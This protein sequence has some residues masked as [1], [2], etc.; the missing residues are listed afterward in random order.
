M[1][2]FLFGE[3]FRQQDEI[4]L[5]SFCRHFVLGGFYLDSAGKQK[6]RFPWTTNYDSRLKCLINIYKLLIS[7]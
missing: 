6:G 1:E 3:F 7:C 4:V 2:F 5:F